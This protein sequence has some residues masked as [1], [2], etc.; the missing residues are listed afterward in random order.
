MK[1]TATQEFPSPLSEHR[2][3]HIPIPRNVLTPMG[4]PTARAA[5]QKFPSPLSEHRRQHNPI[6]R[7]VLTPVGASAAGCKQTWAVLAPLGRQEGRA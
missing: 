6:S 4:A 7:N 2:R 1:K 3:Q 5:L